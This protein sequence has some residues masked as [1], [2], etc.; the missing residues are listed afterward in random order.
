MSK[1]NIYATLNILLKLLYKL[2]KK[3]ELLNLKIKTNLLLDQ[4]FEI[5]LHNY[6]I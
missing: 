3:M 5:L 6:S 4:T 1:M 2:E